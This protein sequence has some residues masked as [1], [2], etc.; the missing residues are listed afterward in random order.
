MKKQTTFYD[1]ENNT[2]GNCM[3]TCYANALGLN[4]DDCPP[5]EKFFDVKYPDT[6]FYQE[7][8]ILWF[9]RL[10]YELK[11][12][13]SDPLPILNEHTFYFAVGPSARGVN[14]MVVYQNGKIFHDPHPSNDG[15][16]LIHYYEYLVPILK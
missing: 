15:L 2:R 6:S 3:I 13:L 9:N 8:L 1:P 10:G 16:E 14:H 4:P 12:S 7:C 5:F 11:T